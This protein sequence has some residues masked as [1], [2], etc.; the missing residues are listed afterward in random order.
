VATDLDVWMLM[1]QAQ[2]TTLGCMAV[3]CQV[4]WQVTMHAD[5]IVWANPKVTCDP[6]RG[7]HV[8]PRI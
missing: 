4:M 3:T 5:W 2:S 6:I 8:A 7:C 1:W